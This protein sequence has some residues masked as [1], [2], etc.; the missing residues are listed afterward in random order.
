MDKER[1]GTED[2]RKLLEPFESQ[3]KYQYFLCDF[4]KQINDKISSN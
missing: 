4:Y 3:F 1:L 2:I